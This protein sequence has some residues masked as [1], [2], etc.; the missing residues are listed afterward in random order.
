[1]EKGEI[2]DEGRRERK[3]RVKGGVD[4]QGCCALCLP[5]YLN[6]QLE[7]QSII[8]GQ[9]K[10]IAIWCLECEIPLR[11]KITTIRGLRTVVKNAK[12]CF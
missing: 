9:I 1:M 4:R 12:E 11:P 2:G 10:N 5:A 6:G 7:K 8:V 3:K